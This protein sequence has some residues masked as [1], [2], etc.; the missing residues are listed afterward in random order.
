MFGDFTEFDLSFLD[1]LKGLIEDEHQRLGEEMMLD[2]DI[3]NSS[4]CQC[5]NEHYKYVQENEIK[6]S[7]QKGFDSLGYELIIIGLYKQCELYL[8]SMVE[9][10]FPDESKIRKRKLAELNASLDEYH[11][12]NE[13]RLINNCIKHQGKVSQSLSSE[14]SFWVVGKDLGDLSVVYSRLKRKVV[15]YIIGHEQYLQKG[16]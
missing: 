6:Q 7:F 13:L 12:I 1:K 10:K 9:L 16:A 3:F 5:E 4:N 11:A 14:Y 8:K 15:S 2:S